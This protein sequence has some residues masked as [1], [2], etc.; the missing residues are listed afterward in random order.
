VQDVTVGVMH[1][2][3][4]PVGVRRLGR[5]HHRGPDAHS[6]L[7]RVVPGHADSRHPSPGPLVLRW[8]AERRLPSGVVQVKLTAP[9]ISELA[10]QTV[11]R[12]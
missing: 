7:V 1:R 8:H 4:L 3:H 12:A 9:G 10:A 2:R 6:V 11:P 5:S